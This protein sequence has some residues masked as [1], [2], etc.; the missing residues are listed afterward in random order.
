MKTVDCIIVGGGMVGASM[1]LSL[2][3]IGLSVT[4][5]EKNTPESFQQDQAIDLR[6][7]AIS[8]ASEQLFE[9]LDVWQDIKQ[10]RVTPYCRLGVWE[11]ELSYTEF[12]AQ[13]INEPHL[14]HIIENRL[15][16]LSLWEKIKQHNNI[17]VFC[18]GNVSNLSYQTDGANSQLPILTVN[19]QEISAKLVVAADGGQSMIRQLAGIG[20]TGW[21]YQQ[22]AMLIHVETER[23]QQDITWQQFTPNGPMA[24]LPLPGQEASLVWYH[25]KA[26]IKRL[27]ALSNEALTEQVT[28]HFPEK[29]GQVKVLSKASFPLTRQHANQYVLNNIVLVGDAAHSINPLAGQGVNLGFKDVK[30]L[31]SVI[32]S[33]IGNAEC[34]YSETVLKRYEVKRRADNALMMTAM[35][36]FY[37]GFSHSLPAIK[38]LRNV[39]LFAAH[40]VPFIKERALAYACGLR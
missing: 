11:T 4:L 16:Q 9:Q 6:V 34:W 33:A 19:E 7:S 8:R 39:G 35:D 18:P 12:N 1:A 21:Q 29:L 40:R 2:A 36:V 23:E 14:G 27:S 28:L 10:M 26:E 38:L 31:Q 24:M 17:D 13:S 20:C 25:D 22:S 15:I 37:K 3:E 32:A 5:I 30:A